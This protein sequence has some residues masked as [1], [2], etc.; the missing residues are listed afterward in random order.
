MKEQ[1][2]YMVKTHTHTF[3][4]SIERHRVNNVF[5]YLRPTAF[6]VPYLE[7]ML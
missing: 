6:Y 2:G 7:A 1:Y 5:L 3:F 4:E